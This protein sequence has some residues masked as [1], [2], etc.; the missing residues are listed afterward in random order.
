MKTNKLYMI[1]ALLGTVL[2]GCQKVEENVPEEKPVVGEKWTLVV[3]ATKG[4][5]TRAMSLDE[6]GN[7]P[8]LNASWAVGE[9]VAVYRNGV[10]AEKLLE[11]TA[12]DNDGKATLSCEDFS[13]EGLAKDDVLM[14]LFPGRDDAKWTYE[15]QDGKSPSVGSMASMFDYAV[16]EVKVD[17]LDTQTQTITTSPTDKYK[18]NSG[19]AAFDNEQSVFRFGFNMSVKSFTISSDAGQLVI[20]RSYQGNAWT[21]TTGSLT[22]S[23]GE[24]VPT[25]VSGRYNY[26]VAI[27]NEN[28]T[29]A[30]RLFF[31]YVDDDG[32]LYEAAKNIPAA[33]L[34]NGNFLNASVNLTP[35]SFA[36][37]AS[38]SISESAG[39]L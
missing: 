31:S 7:A 14:L 17:A 18:D 19:A 27:R 4:V 5:E 28:T 10:K 20:S 36:P 22:V 38:G 9:K 37:E 21:S 8:V 11:V 29:V 33:R 35:K 39:V 32:A 12:V 15:G 23:P 34:G 25:A 3:N 26:Y 30:D 24:Y 1:A 16:A 6:T 2:T 13:I